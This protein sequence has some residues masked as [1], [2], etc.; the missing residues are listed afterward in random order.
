MSAYKVGDDS[1]GSLPAIEDDVTSPSK[2]GTRRESVIVCVLF[3]VSV[4][5]FIGADSTVAA[6][7]KATSGETLS[8]LAATQPDCEISKLNSTLSLDMQEICTVLWDEGMYA[9]VIW[10]VVWAIVWP[11]LKCLLLLATWYLPMKRRVRSTLLRVLEILAH[12]SLVELLLI[13]VIMAGLRIHINSDIDPVMLIQTSN[14]DITILQS[15]IDDSSKLLSNIGLSCSIIQTMCDTD[16][17]NLSEMIPIGSVGWMYC[18]VSC[19][20][21]DDYLLSSTTDDRSFKALQSQQ[22]VD[23]SDDPTGLVAEQGFNCALVSAFCEV[24]IS[25]VSDAAPEGGLGWMF[26]PVTCM[27]CDDFKVRVAAG[28]LLFIGVTLSPAGGGQTPTPIA[29]LSP[30]TTTT[31]IECIDDVVGLVAAQ[32]LTCQLSTTFCKVDMSTISSTIPVGAFGWMLCPV[33]CSACEKYKTAYASG[34]LSFI[35]TPMPLTATPTSGPAVQGFRCVDDITGFISNSNTSCPLLTSFCNV[36]M[37]TLMSSAPNGALGWMYCPVSCKRCSDFI[38]A[39]TDGSLAVI[40][41]TVPPK[42]LT[43][44]PVVS[45]NPPTTGSVNSGM[46][47]DDILRLA[48][49]SGG[50]SIVSTMC[51]TDLGSISPAP[52]GLFGWMLCPVSCKKCSEY[53]TGLSNGDFEFFGL[54]A[55]TSTDSNTTRYPPHCVDDERQHLLSEGGCNNIVNSCDQTFTKN[56]S[57]VK[58]WMLC[59]VTCNRCSSFQDI[60]NA[61]ILRTIGIVW[62]DIAPITTPN[63]VRI[64]FELFLMPE[65]AEYLFFIGTMIAVFWGLWMNQKWEYHIAKTSASTPIENINKISI[66]IAVGTVVGFSLLI[67]GLVLPAFKWDLGGSLDSVTDS[68]FDTKYSVLQLGSELIKLRDSRTFVGLVIMLFCVTLPLVVP[69]LI[70]ATLIL[71]GTL[72]QAACSAMKCVHPFAMVDVLALS[73]IVVDAEIDKILK[74]SVAKRYVSCIP[75]SF[76]TSPLGFI[77]LSSSTEIG[78]YLIVPGIFL[79]HTA[80]IATAVF[81]P[82]HKIRGTGKVSPTPQNI[83]VQVTNT[84]S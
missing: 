69:V 57:A 84:P 39:N 76:N 26:C 80:V 42:V 64:F 41:T 17:S 38:K 3:C 36:N 7:M 21:C 75:P 35:G 18:P 65:T 71:P 5:I 62:T 70:I 48:T 31:N 74:S 54:K 58:G 13:G 68:N 6:E 67:V 8:T 1:E 52:L 19:M 77:H 78:T 22:S 14:R 43:S 81:F 30:G 23:C 34:S 79:I 24:D 53:V 55:N 16:I 37:S 83:D 32:G 45:T 63:T 10:I 56:S 44:I 29:T 72:S 50:C 27:R 51:D 2:M 15:C 4:A 40:W 73:I 20:R 61:A 66:L 46:C 28:D 47:V 11:Y 59:P 25:T 49:S 33:S 82:S 9:V 12:F 60:N